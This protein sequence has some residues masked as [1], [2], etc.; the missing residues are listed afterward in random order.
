MTILS[1]ES[2]TIMKKK[3]KKQKVS[4]TALEYQKLKY[5]LSSFDEDK[6]GVTDTDELRWMVDTLKEIQPNL[7]LPSSQK[8]FYAL[9]QLVD[10]NKDG[11]LTKTEFIE[12]IGIGISEARSNM[13]QTKAKNE[14]FKGAGKE[15]NNFWIACL[16]W[17]DVCKLPEK[18]E[19]KNLDENDKM[20][21]KDINNKIKNRKSSGTRR[22]RRYYNR[23][24]S[25]SDNTIFNRLYDEGKKRLE[26]KAIRQ[27]IYEDKVQNECTFTP[28]VL[29]EKDSID[30]IMDCMIYSVIKNANTEDMDSIPRREMLL[31]VYEESINKINIQASLAKTNNTYTRKNEIHELLYKEAEKK[32]IKFAKRE[33]MRLATKPHGCTFKPEITTFDNKKPALYI[34]KSNDYKNIDVGKKTRHEILYI[35]GTTERT[36]RTTAIK[37]NFKKKDAIFKSV[38]STKKKQSKKNK[39]KDT[40]NDSTKKRYNKEEHLNQ[41]DRMKYLKEKK[42]CTFSPRVKRDKGYVPITGKNKEEIVTKAVDRLAKRDVEMRRKKEIKRSK[43]RLKEN[44]CT[45]KPLITKIAADI[46]E[47]NGSNKKNNAYKRLYET[48]KKSLAKRDK[49]YNERSKPNFKPDLSTSK[50]YYERVVKK[51]LLKNSLKPSPP[52]K[53][54]TDGNDN[55]NDNKTGKLNKSSKSSISPLKR[56]RTSKYWEN[57]IESQVKRVFAN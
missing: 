40:N 41:I 15:I 57:N 28:L 24:V 54:G 39:N 43:A 32:S 38:F 33:K 31:L 11:K 25:S 12:W 36:K 37:E 23:N 3:Q 34:L 52:P 5:W 22:G 8:D 50:S 46:A 7:K 48:G 13:K 6:N 17:I 47:K 35:D 26:R 16:T 55:N 44:G 21:L 45:F 2:N 19:K 4:I 14:P 27:Q 18:L 20:I 56:Y 1:A 53:K 49:V 30:T 51:K 29:N 42:E 9:L 10:F